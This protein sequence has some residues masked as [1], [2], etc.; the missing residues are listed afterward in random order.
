MTD[1]ATGLIA[2][3]HKDSETGESEYKD[4]TTTPKYVEYG[5]ENLKRVTE[6]SILK[7]KGSY[8][9]NEINTESPKHVIEETTVNNFESDDTSPTTLEDLIPVRA[10]RN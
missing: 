6:E 9:S 7:T 5:R 1:S 4:E 10:N 8:E 2:M 3:K